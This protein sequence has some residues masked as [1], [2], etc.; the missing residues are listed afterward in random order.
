[1]KCRKF[2]VEDPSQRETRCSKKTH[3][4]RDMVQLIQS[5]QSPHKILHEY[6]V[7]FYDTEN[8]ISH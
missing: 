6:K 3:N 8:F 4:F 7:V 2:C 1:M 5:F